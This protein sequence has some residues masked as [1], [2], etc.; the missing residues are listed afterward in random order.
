[1]LGKPVVSLIHGKCDDNKFKPNT[2]Y[3]S[4]LQEKRK[5]KRAKNQKTNKNQDTQ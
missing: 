4:S 2:M 1:M 5:N 3:V